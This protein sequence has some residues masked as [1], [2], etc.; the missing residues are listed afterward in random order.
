MLTR[1]AVERRLRR[2]RR[3]T[4]CW[5]RQVEQQCRA[6]LPRRCSVF[7]ASDSEEVRPA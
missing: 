5:V 1:C 2:L 3:A 4:I 6:V 7:V